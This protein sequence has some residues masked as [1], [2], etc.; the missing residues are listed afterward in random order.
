MKRASNRTNDTAADP[1]QKSETAEDGGNASV[2]TDGSAGPAWQVVSDLPGRIRFQFEGLRRNQE[3]APRVEAELACA[4]GVFDWHIRPLTYSLLVHFDTGAITKTQLTHLLDRTIEATAALP[5]REQHPSPARFGLVTGS[6][7]LAA[8]GELAVPALLPASA[9]LL[10]AS[11][12]NVIKLAW[13]ELKQRHIGLPTLFS[14]IIVGTLASGQFLAASL[15][16]WML[17]FWRV[18]APGRPV[19][20]AAQASAITYSAAPVCSAA[21]EWAG[22]GSSHRAARPGAP[23]CHRRGRDGSGRRTAHRRGSPRR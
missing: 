5:E 6:V 14:T 18:S 22:S 10:V 13:R 7:A 17:A 23:N 4:H 19:S 21:R 16:A 8:A 3:L 20:T 1:S 12:L 9:V 15:M 11:N 2:P